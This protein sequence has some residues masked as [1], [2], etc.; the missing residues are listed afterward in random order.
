MMT[1]EKDRPALER[2]A[3]KSK[4]PKY[5][6]IKSTKY[7][8][9]S[10]VCVSGRPGHWMLMPHARLPSHWRAAALRQAKPSQNKHP[11]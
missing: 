8:K 9:K 11:Q 3:A 10:S 2:G 7:F 4:K 6:S 5:L 1:Q